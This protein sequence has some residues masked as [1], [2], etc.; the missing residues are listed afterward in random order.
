MPTFVRQSALPVGASALAA[1]HERPGALE[2]LVPPWERVE[3]RSRTGDVYEGRAEMVI[4]SGLFP[5]RWEAVHAGGVPGRFFVDRQGHGPFRTYAHTHT[6]VPVT[7]TTCELR[8]EIAWE[9]PFG[10]LGA[11]VGDVE[12]RLARG[13]AFRH[14]RTAEDLARHAAFPLGPQRVL[15]SG[16]S[17]LVGA[18]LIAFLQV[19]GHEVIR[20][21]RRAP[22]AG[23]ARWE[24]A[25]GVIDLA[26]VGKIDA[27]I[28]LSG[29]SVSKR[30]T[31]ARKA[32]IIASREQSTLLLASA[33][34]KLETRPRVFISAS[35]VGW[36]GDRG[37][38]VL[39]EESTPGTTGFLPEV[40][41]RW[42]DA[43]K[44]AKDAG[45]SVVN[46]RIGVVLSARGG[47]LAELLPPVLAGVGGPLGAGTQMFPWIAI[48]DLVYLV[49]WLLG[50]GLTGPI[51]ATA[52]TPVSNALFM[53]TIGKVTRRP[54]FLRLP[55]FV[56]ATLFGEMG[57]EVLLGGQN[58]VPA[59]AL[60][61]GFRFTFPD[62][63]SAIRWEL[64]KPKPGSG[65]SG[66]GP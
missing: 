5:I 46:L 50:A 2:R 58:A 6:F 16:A 12:A 40:C 20:L 64:G 13:F 25:Q 34:T 18:Q 29:E 22:R 66:A 1:Y 42:E 14:R 45:I 31:P 10:A 61:A 59:R 26:P 63:E 11:W 32:E 3:V 17:G 48:D 35:A 55:A 56:V 65:S 39:T 47:A 43:T 49:H 19:G 41:R 15:V 27:V 51:H 38:E 52:P 60:A 36:Y 57:R 62:L 24:P 23:E 33:L 54:T 9:A 53:A 8:D 4:R 28:H 21:V 30:W 7:D 44:P 37:Q